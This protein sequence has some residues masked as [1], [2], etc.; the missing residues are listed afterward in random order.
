MAL[1]PRP[2]ATGD[3]WVV[4]WRSP[5]MVASAFWYYDNRDEAEAVYASLQ[6]QAGYEAS[7]RHEHRE[8]PAGQEAQGP[9]A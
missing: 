9:E 2:P 5:S 1:I 8:G 4:A 6:A 3:Y 7:M